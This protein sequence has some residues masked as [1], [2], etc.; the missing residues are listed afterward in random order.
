MPRKR[1]PKELWKETRK[2]V[3]LR[4]GRKCVHCLI[5]LNLKEAH[6]DHIQSGKYG[7]N[8]MNNLRTLCQKCHILRADKRH[9]GMIGNALRKGI[10]PP[11]WRNLIW[12]D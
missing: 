7:T 6:I 5:S 1:Q 8:H 3:Y 10:I 12:E 4:D 11:Y 2:K 9:R